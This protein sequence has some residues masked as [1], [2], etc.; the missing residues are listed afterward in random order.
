MAAT[1][2]VPGLLIFPN[3]FVEV[4]NE[5][6]Q[7]HERRPGESDKEKPGQHHHDAVGESNHKGILNHSTKPDYANPIEWTILPSDPSTARHD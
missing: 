6:N 3:Q 4:L 2:A 1:S 5:T 7:D